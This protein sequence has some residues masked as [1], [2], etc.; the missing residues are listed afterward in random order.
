MVLVIQF[1]YFYEI[2]FL[3]KNKN[4]TR[5]LVLVTVKYNL[6][7]ISA[8]FSHIKEITLIEKMFRKNENCIVN[9]P[10]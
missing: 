4:L 6:K 2:C 3:R 9:L 5:L 7:F 1:S 10:V 8:L